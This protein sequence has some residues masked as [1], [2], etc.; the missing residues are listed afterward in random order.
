MS[1]QPTMA[2]YEDQ[3]T[4]WSEYRLDPRGFYVSERINAH[5]QVE[6]RYPEPEQPAPESS[7]PRYQQIP[8]RQSTY[9][10]SSEAASEG[11]SSSPNYTPYAPNSTSYRDPAAAAT[12]TKQFVNARNTNDASFDNEPSE[13]N[14]RFD[15]PT[16]TYPMSFSTPAAPSRDPSSSNF[17]PGVAGKQML[18]SIPR[19]SFR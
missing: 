16:P 18:T 12:S 5:G 2:S 9:A 1:Y 19:L 14:D 3:S 11:T 17:C 10:Q 13:E 15:L 4:Q 7:T 6:Y 8:D